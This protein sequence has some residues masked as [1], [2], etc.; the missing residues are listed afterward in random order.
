ML[1]PKYVDI[2]KMRVICLEV[3]VYSRWY[4]DGVN[5]RIC[6]NQSAEQERQIKSMQLEREAMQ[7]QF[8][9]ASTD[10]ENAIQ[11][12]RKLQDDLAAA[13]C[14]VRNMQRELESSH[15]ECYDLKRQLQTYVSE[16]RRVEEQLNRKVA[17][18]GK[19]STKRIF[20]NNPWTLSNI[21]ERFFQIF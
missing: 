9:T 21:A 16:V 1:I 15:A 19:Y 4:N 14:E 2:Y 17:K 20:A 18:S 3:W 5:C 11:E 6:I 7:R 8:E 10:R 13:T 12:N